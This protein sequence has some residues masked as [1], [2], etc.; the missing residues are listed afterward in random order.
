LA[1]WHSNIVAGEGRASFLGRESVVM[2]RLHE[3]IR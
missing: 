1:Q 3:M 2:S